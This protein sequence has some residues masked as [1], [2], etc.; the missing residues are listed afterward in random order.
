MLSREELGRYS[1]QMLLPEIGIAGQEKLRSASVFVIGAGGLGCPVL[2]YLVSAGVGRIGIIDH[3]IVDLSNLQRQILYNDTD[4]GLSKALTAK[5]KL[6]LLNPFV[7]IEAYPEKLVAENAMTLIGRYDLVIDGSDN[8]PTR[9]L[10]NDS[11]VAAGIPLV[12]GSILGFEGQISVF[13]YKGGPNYRDV[14]T[15]APDE[16]ESPNCTEIGVVGAL[17]G[18]IG[19]YM[20]A[21]A[22]KII[23]GF[24]V[25]LSGKLLIL[26]ML[27]HQ[28]HIFTI[29]SKSTQS[30]SKASVKFQDCEIDIVRFRALQDDVSENIFLVDVRENYEFEAENIGGINIPLYE[31]R[32]QIA[33]LPLDKKLVFICETGQRSKMAVQLLRPMLSA[34]LY[35]LSGRFSG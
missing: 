33:T 29:G 22:I 15:E 3:D 12:F 16:G 19:T 25:I 34:E 17:P 18:V 13:N 31:L 5:R 20:A 28:Q 14:F 32:E 1:R 8:F 30:E 9:Y 21:E 10:V 4:I 6:E 24:G 35:Y 27:N 7:M 2:Q 26:N 23:C 11:C